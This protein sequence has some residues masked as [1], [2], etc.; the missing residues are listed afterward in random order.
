MS[1]QMS[2]SMSDVVSAS[3]RDVCGTTAFVSSDELSE[4]LRDWKLSGIFVVRVDVDASSRGRF[5]DVVDD[6]IDAALTAHGGLPPSMVGS[7]E[8]D[9]ACSDRIFRARRLGFYGI[10]IVFAS[11][12]TAASSRGTLDADDCASL[13]ALADMTRDRPLWVAFDR[14]DRDLG[15]HGRPIPFS[16]MFAAASAPPLKKTSPV[17]APQQQHLRAIE[18]AAAITRPLEKEIVRV[19][20]PNPATIGVSIATPEDV[21]RGWMLS[22]TAARGPQSLATFERLFVEA[23]LPL[24]HAITMGLEDPR[25]K[26]AMLVFRRTFE[27]AYPEAAARFQATTKRPAM[28]LDAPQNAM[29]LARSNGARTSQ[30]ILVEAMRYDIGIK[31]R[32][33]LEMAMGARARLV[34]DARL[35]AALPTTSA[36]QLET[37]ARGAEAL[38]SPAALADDSTL[39][40][41]AGGGL[42]KIRAGG[43]ELYRLDMIDVAVQNDAGAASHH[44]DDLAENVAE[45]IASHA[46]ALRG[47]TLLYILGD[48]GF[49]VDAG[50]RARCGGSTPEEVIV[51]AFAFIVDA[52][53]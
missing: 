41:Q 39:G 12:K 24:L 16:A 27:G 44:F 37:I 23:Y 45:T 42:R 29:R 40:S 46:L 30:I 14:S 43:R 25:A 52:V 4:R 15:A 22:L 31:V 53:Q 28:V 50:G 9:A 51:P 10:A 33:A 36:R 20:A 38:R 13:R 17:I 26:A 8:R 35:H 47:R 5:E 2:E 7:L 34:E 21:W 49:S 48:R 1:Q 6:A 11:L 18:A 32:D 3:P 19:D